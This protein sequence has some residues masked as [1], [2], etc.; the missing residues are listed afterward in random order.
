MI[1]DF[2]T[3]LFAAET[4]TAEEIAA[5][6]A[7]AQA[8]EALRVASVESAMT[9]HRLRPACGRCHGSGRIGAFAHV[10]GGVCFAC[11]GDGFKA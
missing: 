8:A 11:G 4:R 1:T 2:L 7:A 6:M 9:A 3:E 5:S 10:S